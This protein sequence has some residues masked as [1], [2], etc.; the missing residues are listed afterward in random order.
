MRCELVKAILRPRERHHSPQ[1]R[2]AVLTRSCRPGRRIRSNGCGLSLGITVARRFGVSVHVA[3]VAVAFSFLLSVYY[4]VLVVFHIS[5][6]K[7]V[8]EFLSICVLDFELLQVRH[9]RT[10]HTRL[11]FG[12]MF[13]PLCRYN[14]CF[15]GSD[16]PPYGAHCV[17]LLFGRLYSHVSFNFLC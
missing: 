8:E 4:L 16:L 7:L 13:S 14:S 3:F 6:S 11:A 12:Q 15:I 10:I 2:C 17:R 9:R 1:K 5:I